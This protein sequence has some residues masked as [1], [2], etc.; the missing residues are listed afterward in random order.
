MP[1]I[2]T[3]PSA[4]T[5]TTQNS[6]EPKSANTDTN[7]DFDTFI[8][9]LTSQIKNQDPANPLDSTELATQLAT[10]SGVEQQVLTN[11]I[12]QNIFDELSE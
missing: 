8:K 4:P 5:T 10:F 9:I 12:L 7:S 11:K 6:T 1:L 2:E 3:P